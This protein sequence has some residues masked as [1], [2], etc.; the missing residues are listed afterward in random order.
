MQSNGFLGT[1]LVLESKDIIPDS[2]EWK[3]PSNIAIVKYWGKH[4]RQLP[5]NPSISGTLTKAHTQTKMSWK[6]KSKEAHHSS[7]D[8]NFTFE[9]RAKP[10]FEKRISSYLNSLLPQFPFLDQLSIEIESTNSF[11]HSS[12][13]AS[14]ASAM[15]AIALCLCSAEDKLFGTLSD[16]DEFEKKASYI[17]RLGSGSAARSIFGYWSLWGETG[18]WPGSSDA[19]AVSL[20]EHVHE[21]FSNMKDAILIV[22]ERKKSVS[23]SAGHQLMEENPYASARYHLARNRIIQLLHILNKGDWEGFAGLAEGEALNLHGL[24]MSSTP[25]YMLLEPAS[26][27]LIGIIRSWRENHDLPVCFTLDAGPNLHVLYPNSHAKE[28]EKRL[29][30][31]CRPICQDG[32]IIFDE[33][34]KGPV[35]I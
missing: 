14:S 19:F 29:L 12:G 2:V 1:D 11:P 13:I 20:Q 4:G 15:S 21:N 34:G 31:E 3:S 16:D 18:E 24:M 32:Q 8:L 9:G 33:L 28:I 5:Q 25:G 10:A 26:I 17:A 27:E 23:S 6:A 35:E 7:I 30:E 22:S